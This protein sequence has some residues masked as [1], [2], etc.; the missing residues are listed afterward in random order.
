MERSETMLP[1]WMYVKSEIPASIVPILRMDN[2]DQTVMKSNIDV[3]E[4]KRA[5]ERNE[6]EEPQEM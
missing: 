1:S 2:D 4:P 3:F 5:N 6:N